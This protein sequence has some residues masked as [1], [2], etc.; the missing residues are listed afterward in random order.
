[1]PFLWY[2]VVV[3]KHCYVVV[4]RYWI[5]RGVWRANHSRL[6]NDF[7]DV[8]RF[9]QAGPLEKRKRPGSFAATPPTGA[10]SQRSK[11]RPKILSKKSSLTTFEAHEFKTLQIASPIIHTTPRHRHVPWKHRLWR[12]RRL[13]R[14]PQDKRCLARTG[15]RATSRTSRTGLDT[16]LFFDFD[17]NITTDCHGSLTTNTHAAQ[18]G[19]L[20]RLAQSL[21]V[22]LS[23]CLDTTTLLTCLLAVTT[24]FRPSFDPRPRHRS[25]SLLHP[26]HRHLCR[27]RQDCFCSLFLCTLSPHPPRQ[28]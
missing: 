19:L 13:S 7:L 3:L 24:S 14:R 15:A 23:A 18:V 28:P 8:L 6:L 16:I 22:T 21:G 2:V 17:F 25:R 11:C 27:R 4:S 10:K 9:Q 20:W 1:M 5:L 26:S 12:R